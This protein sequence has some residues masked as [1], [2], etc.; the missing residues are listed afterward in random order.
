M[1]SAVPVWEQ[2]KHISLDLSLFCFECRHGDLSVRCRKKGGGKKENK[3]C[4]TILVGGDYWLCGNIC[5][6]PKILRYSSRANFMSIICDSNPRD[7]IF[8]HSDVLRAQMLHVSSSYRGSS[9]FQFS[10]LCTVRINRIVHV[11]NL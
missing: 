7:R 10:I 2:W 9:Y 3:R 11:G 5:R 4:G 6:T 1:S 8:S